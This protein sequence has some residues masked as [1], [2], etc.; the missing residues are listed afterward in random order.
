MS[1]LQ[2]CQ[3]MRV[4]LQFIEL[5]T[6]ISIIALETGLSAGMLRKLYLEHTGHLPPRGT[7]PF[8]AEWFLQWRP[9]VHASLFANLYIDLVKA[10]LTSPERLTAAYRHYLS[11]LACFD[12][13]EP[14]LSMARAWTLLRFCRHQILQLTACHR[15][16]GH[17]ISTA[18]QPSSSFVCGICRTPSHAGHHR[19]CAKRLLT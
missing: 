8:S 19:R 14:L 2:R 17:Y 16:Q 18:Y 10:G 11:E 5:N 15:C 12:D 4:A 7:L 13:S 9:N 1:L 6:P 3:K